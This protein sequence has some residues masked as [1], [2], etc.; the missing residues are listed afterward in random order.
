M[1]TYNGARYLEK[2]L[3]S[4]LEQTYNNWELLIR[5]DGSTDETLSIL[6]RYAEKC[7]NIRICKGENIGV[8]QS[9]FTLLQMSDDDAAFYGFADQ[10][11]VWMPEKLEMAI[12]QLEKENKQKPLL[13]CSDTYLTDETLHIL[14]KD[15]KQPRPSWGNALVQNICTGC[16]AVFNHALRDIVKQTKPEQIIMHDWW[17]YLTATLYGSVVYDNE[18]YIKYRQHKGNIHGAKTSKIAVWKYRFRQLKEKR[19]ELY[20]QLAEAA[21]WYRGMDEDKK[22]LLKRVLNAK[23][24]MRNRIRLIFDRRVYRNGRMDDIVYRGIVLIGKL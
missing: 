17:L 22:Q 16:T 10:D 14:K 11:D 1:S 19:G 8:I 12:A 4:I 13:Y 6:Q 18:A 5:D 9:F 2:Q 7:D 3:D 23:H 15:N 20:L 21:Q 24:G